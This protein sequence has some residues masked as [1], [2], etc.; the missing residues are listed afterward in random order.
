[1]FFFFFFLN[2]N[3]LRFFLGLAVTP[4]CNWSDANL[5]AV[6]PQPVEPVP[7]VFSVF[8]AALPSSPLLIR[9]VLYGREKNLDCPSSCHFFTRNS[10]SLRTPT[11]VLLFFPLPYPHSCG[12]PENMCKGNKDCSPYCFAVHLQTTPEIIA[13]NRTRLDFLRGSG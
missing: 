9:F 8:S 6:F 4:H 7:L 10:H 5:H 13:N 2:I 12:K 3:F 11:K 1:M